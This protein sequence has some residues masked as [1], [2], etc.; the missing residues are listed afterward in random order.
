LLPLDKVLVLLN[1]PESTSR[2]FKDNNTKDGY[3]TLHL[4]GVRYG[5]FDEI[6]V[7]FIAITYT[8]RMPFPEMRD[9]I[10]H[11]YEKTKKDVSW[12]WI[13]IFSINQ[14]DEKSVSFFWEDGAK[15][16]CGLY[17]K[18]TTHFVLRNDVGDRLWCHFE[19]VCSVTRN[20]IDAKSVFD[21]T[22]LTSEHILGIISSICFHT[23]VN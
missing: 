9:A 18:A 4:D 5:T 1:S 7:P 17:R 6:D 3:D 22:L 13:D 15:N 21:A 10:S 12:C 14:K 11:L 16:S 8:W 19:L 2:S 23:L 20:M